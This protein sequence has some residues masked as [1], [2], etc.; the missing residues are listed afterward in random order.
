MGKDRYGHYHGFIHPE[1]ERFGDRQF[2]HHGWIER[3]TTIVDPTRWVFECVEPYIYVGPKDDEDYDFGGNRVKAMYMRPAPPFDP[4]SGSGDTWELP[5][6]IERF[7]KFILGH[8]DK[9]VSCVQVMWLANLPLDML[10]EF[11]KPVYEFI[12][13]KVGLPGMI[14]MD[15]RG[16]ILG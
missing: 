13:N 12:I 4:T 2:T 6:N 10:G 5:D 11:A 3:R 8:E 1:C 15:N 7:A 14:P 16:E 9:T